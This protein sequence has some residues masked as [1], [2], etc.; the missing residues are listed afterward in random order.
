MSGDGVRAAASATLGTI[1]AID[2]FGTTATARPNRIMRNRKTQKITTMS[3][4]TKCAT[5]RAAHFAIG[6]GDV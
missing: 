3:S 1:A 4:E 6:V 2:T 5:K